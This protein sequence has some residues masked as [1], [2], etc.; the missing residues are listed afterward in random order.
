[1]S[2][3]P[4]AVLIAL[5][6]SACAQAPEDV[7]PALVS[8]AP[9]LALPCDQLQQQS[10][11]MRVQVAEASARQ[12]KARSGDTIGVLLIGLP[13]SSMSGQDEAKGLAQLKGQQRAIDEAAAQNGCPPP[14]G[15][16][17]R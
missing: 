15:V 9:Y 2:A 17:P 10:L 8:S 4:T 5:A 13:T 11:A 16:P 7:T 14:A 6:L 1:M 3:K 12:T